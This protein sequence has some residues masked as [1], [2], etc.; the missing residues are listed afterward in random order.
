MT[1]EVIP[2]LTKTQRRVLEAV[3][4]YA[5]EYGHS[6][7]LRDIGDRTGLVPSA[8]LYQVR[9]LHE[10]G[11]IRKHPRRPRALVVLN[12]RGGGGAA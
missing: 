11:W 6:P 8:V 9:R 3:R 4:A 1:A 12:P 10:M 7:S 5:T 2:M